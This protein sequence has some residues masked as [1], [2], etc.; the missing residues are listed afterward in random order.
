MVVYHH[1]YRRT[2][3]SRLLCL[4]VC[5]ICTNVPRPEQGEGKEKEVTTLHRAFAS[6]ADTLQ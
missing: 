6:S 5:A 4:E 2:C 3:H 1:M